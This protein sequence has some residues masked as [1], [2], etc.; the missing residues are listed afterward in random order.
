MEDNAINLDDIFNSVKEIENNKK[1]NIKDNKSISEVEVKTEDVDKEIGDVRETTYDQKTE[2]VK[3]EFAER[4]TEF[5]NLKKEL[6]SKE[7]ALNDTKRSYQTSNQKL[8]L[9]KKKFNSTLE[10]LKNNLLN[11]DNTLLD[12]EELNSAINKLKSVFSFNE[13][14]LEAKEE[15]KVDNKSKTI[16]E[17]LENE[18]AN[19]KKYNKSKDLEANY[20]AFFDSVHLLDVE[21]RQ[22]L[23]DYLEEAEPV[24]S[25]EKLL[26]LGKDYRN[27]FESGLKT[28]KNI[29][30]YVA[31]LHNQITRLTEE[32]NKSKQS[33]DNNFENVD[34]KHIRS[35]YSVSDSAYSDKIYSEHDKSLLKS[36]N[37]LK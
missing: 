9:S 23:L 35:R 15:V 4:E 27:L 28:H 26:M 36:L 11:P 5:E 30:A 34:N 19:F 13:E 2:E 8:V 32:S 20:K 6:T 24:D 37:I 3:L 21:E 1:P 25:I 18:F 14:D 17:K 29:F 7:K 22:S 33:I 12:D 31:D 16:L 10:E